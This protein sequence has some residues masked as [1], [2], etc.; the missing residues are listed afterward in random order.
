M[1]IAALLGGVSLV[2]MAQIWFKRATTIGS[3]PLL[4]LALSLFLVAQAGFYLALREIE[5]GKVY[6]ATALTHV[7][8]I[9]L[10]WLYL[11]ERI[12][13]RQLAAIGTIVTGVAIYGL[14]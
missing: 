4:A 9:V 13:S 7:L 8:V 12:N 3:R 1:G 5:V 11:R 14:T 2:A 6:M 10:A